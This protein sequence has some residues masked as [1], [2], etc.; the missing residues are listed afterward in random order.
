[1]LRDPCQAGS[2]WE[3]LDRAISESRRNR[4]QLQE[5]QPVTIAAIWPRLGAAHVDPV[6][7]TGSNRAHRVLRQVVAE[8]PAGDIPGSVRVSASA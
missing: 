1:M 4:A 5:L 8:S 2:F 7:A 3:A 6:F